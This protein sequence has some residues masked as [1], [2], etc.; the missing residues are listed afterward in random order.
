MCIECKV[1]YFVE[2]SIIKNIFFVDEGYEYE[3]IV[4]FEVI[5]EVVEEGKIFIFFWE[6]LFEIEIEF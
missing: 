4:G 6:K 2:K 5:D 1:V 3:V